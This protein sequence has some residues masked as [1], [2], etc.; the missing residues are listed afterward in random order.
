MA[1][2][3]SQEPQPAGRG[4]SASGSQGEIPVRDDPPPASAVPRSEGA[5]GRPP[6]QQWFLAHSDG[7][8]EGPMSLEAL[9][10]RAA[11]GEVAPADLLWR[12]GMPVWIPARECRTCSAGRALKGR[13]RCRRRLRSRC[14]RRC[15]AAWPPIEALLA[16]PEFFRRVARICALAAVPVLLVSLLTIYWQRESLAWALLLALAFFVGEA[17]AAVLDRLD[18]IESRLPEDDKAGQPP[19]DASEK[20]R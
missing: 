1:D 7:R 2:E 11:A 13:R 18:Q 3:W 12:E 20:L 17:A 14:G 9:R 5:A 19:R 6:G 8:R 15:R 16:T 4:G 10:Q